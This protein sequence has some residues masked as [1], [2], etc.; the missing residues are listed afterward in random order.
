MGRRR[1]RDRL[2]NAPP[3]GLRRLG[4]PSLGAVSTAGWTGSTRSSLRS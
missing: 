4:L 1:M 2:A 3:E